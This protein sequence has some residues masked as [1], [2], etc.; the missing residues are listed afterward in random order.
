MKR[1]IIDARTMPVFNTCVEK[2][3]INLLLQSHDHRF[4]VSQTHI[5]STQKSTCV[6]LQGL[7][8]SS[9]G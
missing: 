2:S 3:F 6:L 1:Q 5:Y 4:K 8:S 7:V 9:S